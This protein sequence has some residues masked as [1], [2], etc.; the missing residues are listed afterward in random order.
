MFKKLATYRNLFIQTAKLAYPI[1]IGQLGLVLMGLIDTVM[2]GR[3][4]TDA[5]GAA[6]VGNAV[7]FLFMLI[8]VGAMYAVS[9]FTAIADGEGR[10]QQ[11]IPIF[12]SSLRI[13]AVLSVILFGVNLFFVYNFDLFKQT[14]AVSAMGADFL[15]VVNFS[16]PAML[17]YNSG[18]QT[19]D[20]L[21]KTQISM[22]VTAIGVGLNILLNWVMIYGNWGCPPMGVVGSAWAT[23]ISRYVMAILMLGWTWYHP[24]IMELKTRVIEKI[25]YDRAILRTGLP[26]GFTFFFEMAAF[27]V[28]LIM[29]GWISE[30]H[31]AAHQIAI[32]L[33]SVTYMIITG[34][35]TGGNILVGNFYGARDR[36]GVRKAGFAAILLSL[37]V[38]CVF[39]LMFLL[40][41]GELPKMYTNDVAVINMA[42]ELL[43]LAA[44]FQLSD[45]IQAVAAGVLRG[46]KDT[47]I[48]GIIAFVSYWVI[49]VPGAYWLCFELE[50]G[51][52]GI[53]FAF[54]FGLT[55]A[56]IWLIMRFFNKS[57]Y[58]S[59]TFE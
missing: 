3:V 55:F 32:N 14:A 52:Q 16:V 41:S 13:S 56:A 28:A 1:T 8:G 40:L 25:S 53:W 42:R 37:V 57:D 18:K 50:W 34:I 31:L 49:M 12:I 30:V 7:S 15:W 36:L 59:L 19:M 47:R 39:A 26:I 58:Y 20:G 44:F 5:M 35:A 22:V 2:L 6:S 54:I 48:T 51:I 24:Y 21:G 29:C 4:S 23:T 33:A 17:F 38:E 9:T 45:G 10:P 27:T 43:F 11:G 46:I